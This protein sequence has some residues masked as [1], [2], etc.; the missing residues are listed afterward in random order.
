MVG[1]S[2]SDSYAPTSEVGLPVADRGYSENAVEG[3]E[4]WRLAVVQFSYLAGVLR[5]VRTIHNV[6]GRR[7]V[8]IMCGH[9]V[10]VLYASLATLVS[11]SRISVP[12]ARRDSFRIG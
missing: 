3:V 2:S 12:S 4:L 6:S 10:G 1:L 5:V 7:C 9:T 11:F 8:S